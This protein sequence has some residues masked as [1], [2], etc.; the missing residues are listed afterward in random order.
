MTRPV[1]VYAIFIKAPQEAVFDALTD[2]V[3]TRDYWLHENASDWKV[4]STWRH[5]PTEGD[6]DHGGGKVLEVDRPNRLVFSWG[7]TTDLSDPEKVGQVTFTLSTQ[8]GATRLVVTHE[9]ISEQELNDVSEGW[10]SVLSSLKSLL[11]TGTSLGDLWGRG[12][13]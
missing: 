12:E 4:G 10:P 1:F 2:P 11:E 7:E 6:A 13:A 8:A 5:V 9:V 3:M